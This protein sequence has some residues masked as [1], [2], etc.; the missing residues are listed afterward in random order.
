[1]KHLIPLA[2]L[3]LTLAGCST[4][5][6]D[7][8]TGAKP[9]VLDLGVIEVSDG[10]QS[11]HDL[12]GGRICVITPDVQEDGEMVL[13][14]SVEEAGK[15]LVRPRVQT[16][17]GVPFQ[18]FV[19]DVTVHMR[20]VV[21]GDDE[22]GAALPGR[23]MS[24]SLVADIALAELPRGSRLRCEFKAGVWEV[25]EVQP[26]VWGESSVI[27][28]AAGKVLISSTNATRVALRVRDA[29]GMVERV[30][31]PAHK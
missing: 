8:V 12:G 11:R 7:T 20:P 23:R 28:N 31:P 4:P 5:P 10:V 13:S 30:P 2:A 9:G 14:M 26:G 15:V 16:R 18:F 27:T 29:D 3:A 17:S 6:P 21:K 25:L 24:E 19:G 22:Q 1:M